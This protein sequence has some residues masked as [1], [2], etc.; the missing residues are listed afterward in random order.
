MIIAKKK[1]KK[2]LESIVR[3]GTI[4]VIQD[5]KIEGIFE[6]ALSVL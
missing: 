6:E 1:E 5:E 4:R 2:S 3:H